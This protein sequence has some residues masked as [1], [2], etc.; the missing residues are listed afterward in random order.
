MCVEYDVAAAIQSHIDSAGHG[1]G[2]LRD[3]VGHGIGRKM[4]E[5]PTVFNYRVADLG[6]EVRPGLCLAIE[7]MVTAGSDATFVEDDDWVELV[8]ADG[9]PRLSFQLS[10]GHIPPVW[11]GDDGD[12]QSH[13]DIRVDDLAVAHE[14][15]LAAGARP[16]DRPDGQN[17]GFRVYLDPSGHP[18]CTVD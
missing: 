13:L 16:V 1:Y 6:P 14:Q 10:P 11:P 9:D 5:G 8:S 2:I 3:Y 4:H 15:L 17:T 18:F 12:Q 7:P